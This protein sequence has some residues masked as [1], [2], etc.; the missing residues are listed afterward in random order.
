MVKLDKSLS[1]AIFKG[2]LLQPGKITCSL[3]NKSSKIKK[4]KIVIMK[5]EKKT[6]VQVFRSCIRE[7]TALII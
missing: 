2:P 6:S 4:K 7:D 5:Q 3:T 1:S